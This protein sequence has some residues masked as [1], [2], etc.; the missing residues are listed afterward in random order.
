MNELSNF[1]IC[2]T[3]IGADIEKI[4][5]SDQLNHA[6]FYGQQFIA[7]TGSVDIAVEQACLDAGIQHLKKP[8]N[9]ITVTQDLTSSL[10]QAHEALKKS[11]Q[12]ILVACQNRSTQKVVSAE[13]LGLP[14]D[15]NINSLI[16]GGGALALVISKN[17]T[18][19]QKIYCDITLKPITTDT[20][21]EL[22]CH[23]WSDCDS[24]PAVEAAYSNPGL[25]TALCSAQSHF[26]DWGPSGALLAL[27]QSALALYHRYL[28]SSP[29][30]QQAKSSLTEQWLNSSQF[31]PQNT[32]F[33]F[34][35]AHQPVRVAQVS[36]NNQHGQQ[37]QVWLTDAHC[38]AQRPNQALAHSG[39]HL[40]P[41]CGQSPQQ[42]QQRLEDLIAESS[43]STLADLSQYCFK[44]Y[45]DQPN[46]ELGL[47]I[48]AES[49]EDFIKEAQVMLN[50]LQ[51]TPDQEIKTPKGSYY[52][53]APLG[54]KG[55]LAFT[56]PGMGSS[57]V[58]LGHDIFHLFPNVYELASEQSDE[59]GE[60][61]KA[62]LL[63]PRDKKAFSFKEKKL[64]DLQFHLDVPSISETDTLFAWITTK[65][66]THGLGVNPDLALGYSLGEANM[67]F[68]LDSWN[69]P[70]EIKKK[71]DSSPLFREDL[72]G[73]MKT[74][75][76]QWQTDPQ[77]NNQQLW[78]TFALRADPAEVARLIE[79][80]PQ[81]FISM[82]NTQDNLVI[83][84]NPDACQRIIEQLGTR[85]I[86]MG[87]VPA[88]HVPLAQAKYDDITALYTHPVEATPDY[89]LYSTSCYLPVPF[90]SQAIARA[91]G[92]CF[93]DPVDFPRLINKTYADGARIFLET[94]AGRSCCTWIDRILA[95]KPHVCIPINAKG[96]PDS[97]TL[98]RAAAKLYSHRVSIDL[99]AFYPLHQPEAALS[100]A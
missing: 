25:T 57:Y 9:I 16:S 50:A 24:L 37:Q 42:L 98:A 89:K 71:G 23:H 15:K 54:G 38:G 65:V 85:A 51:Q 79:N 44:H 27:A 4:S 19:H 12:V 80:E 33:W 62:D 29:Q 20:N 14:L 47:M 70:L 26:G 17:P 34:T 66:L 82:I 36:W 83:A 7:S 95:D 75:R 100:A 39:V 31:V 32:Q 87:F 40:L 35:S 97:L 58:G 64:Q 63:Y 52:T 88:L 53:A 78:G 86:P 41:I 6:F 21:I 1:D 59:V 46:A 61:F 18:A 67:F 2:I 10:L 76:Q 22:A 8:L 3:G 77:V 91:I 60:V 81:V 92:K 93:C 30:W 74:V 99:S 96:T 72:Y 55:K 49:A 84:G 45:G 69:D 73:E 90:R 68:A 43:Y 11:S 94:G 13:S 5:T 48:L 28:P 56:Y